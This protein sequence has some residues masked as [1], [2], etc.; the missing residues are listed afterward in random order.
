MVA[1]AAQAKQAAEGGGEPGADLDTAMG[2]LRS[3]VQLC[4]V[5]NVI[6]PG[7]AAAVEETADGAGSGGGGNPFKQ[8]ENISSF[9][10]LCR[11]C[12]V[13][14]FDLFETNDLFEARNPQQVL[15]CIHALGKACATVPGFDGPFLEHGEVVDTIEGAQS[16]ATVALAGMSRDMKRRPSLPSLFSAGASGGSLQ[17]GGSMTVERRGSSVG[18]EVMGGVTSFSEEIRRG[19]GAEPSAVATAAA[20]PAPAPAP[21]AA[22]AAVAAAPVAD[23][24]SLPPAERSV[25]WWLAFY[26]RDAAAFVPEYKALMADSPELANDIAVA[27]K[28]G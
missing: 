8:R 17:T 25:A 11:E 13:A 16:A 23:E 19:G 27:L 14:E 12:N 18:S 5:M 3:G 22:A 21:V 26:R 7:S 6:L 4:R 24:A 28:S 20:T 2:A 1:A 9:L 15:Q 10:R